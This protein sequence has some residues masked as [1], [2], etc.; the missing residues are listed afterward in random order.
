MESLKLSFEAVMP[1]FILMMLGYILKNLRVAD[2]KTF[3]AINKLVF[4]VFL[5]VLLFQNIYS[6]DTLSS[7]DARI[8]LFIIISVLVV[9]AVGFGFVLVYTKDNSKRGVMLQGFFRSNYA[10]L[11][12]PL[13]DFI[14]GDSVTGLASV[15]VAVIVPLFNVLAVISLEVF[16]KDG[17][18]IDIKKLVVGVFKNPLI[19]GCIFGIVFAFF[20]VKLPYVLDKAVGDIA[21]IATPL[22]IITLGASFTFSSVRG[23]LREII[24]VVSTKLLWVP[25]LTLPVAVLL[26]FSGEALA[27]LLIAY[28][29]PVAVSSFSMAQQMGGDE[30]LAAQLVVISSA[31]C[32]FTLFVWIFV[33]GSLGLF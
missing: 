5:P 25:L 15:L 13:V 2:E 30:K 12:I 7:I 21:K 23:Y 28:A 31:A 4:K 9:F 22:A 29:S 33:L 18:G 1:I 3:S 11:G 19:I 10:I 26:G 17:D 24:I 14:C 8:S 20:G 6:G 27:S 16:N 32:L